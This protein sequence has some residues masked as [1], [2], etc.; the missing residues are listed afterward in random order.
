MRLA[1]RNVRTLRTG[2]PNTCGG[3][4]NVQDLRKTAVIDLELKRLNIAVTALQETRIPDEGS[5]RE[6]HYTFFWRGKE[7]S[8]KREHGVGFAIRNDLLPSLETTR[9][10]S[11]I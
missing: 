1:T 8:A 6:S 7:E 2:L 4:G 5:I 3:L 9:G 11:K 10:I